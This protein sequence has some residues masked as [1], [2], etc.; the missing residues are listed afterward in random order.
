MVLMEVVEHVDPSR[1]DALE[2]AVFDAAHP[3]SVVLTTPNAEYNALYP[4]LPAGDRRHVD[5]RFEW[6]RDQLPD[7]GRRGRRAVTDTGSTFRPIGA[8]DADLGAPTQLA[9]FEREAAA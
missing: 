1:L 6:T 3:A 2:D 8:E 5:H 4:G 9:L 7:V